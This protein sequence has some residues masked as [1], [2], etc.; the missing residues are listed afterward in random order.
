M[1]AT[2]LACYSH[3]ED[4]AAFDKHYA[5]VHAELGRALPG[6]Q[7]FTGTHADPGPDGSPAPYYFVAVLTF[8]DAETMGAA[9][10]GPEGAAAVADLKNFAGAGV[11]LIT[12]TT[13]TF[14]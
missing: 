9:L 3:P 13:T 2:L 8:G 12:G 10:S 5:E 4:P 7:S 1:T 6:L 11:H 14:A